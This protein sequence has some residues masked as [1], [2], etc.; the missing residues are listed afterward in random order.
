MERLIPMNVEQI[1]RQG[2]KNAELQRKREKEFDNQVQSLSKHNVGN[3]YDVRAIA[4]SRQFK[5]QQS[6]YSTEQALSE[7]EDL[8]QANRL[9]KFSDE[10]TQFIKKVTGRD[11]DSYTVRETGKFINSI[12]DELKAQYEIKE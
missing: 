1:R 4:K 9:Y 12:I 8:L 3:L 6:H 5:E 10:T 2:M 7:L 11:Y